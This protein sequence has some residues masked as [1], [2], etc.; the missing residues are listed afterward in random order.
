MFLVSHRKRPARVKTLPPAVLP[1]SHLL[2]ELFL[3]RMSSRRPDGLYGESWSITFP[4]ASGR[5]TVDR[6]LSAPSGDLLNIVRVP[7]YLHPIAT[8]SFLPLSILSAFLRL[9]MLLL[10][11]R[12]TFQRLAYSPET[13]PTNLG[14]RCPELREC[15]S[16][17]SIVFFL[18]PDSPLQVQHW[19]SFAGLQTLV[20]PGSHVS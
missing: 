14:S 16:T 1:S 12:T 4:T 10:S 11:Q 9:E 20:I 5:P 17:V 3:V 7:Q 6:P 15:V 13:D 19:R 8:T 2:L 18:N